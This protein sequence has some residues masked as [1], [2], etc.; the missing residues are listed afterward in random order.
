M[1][2]GRG[3]FRPAGARHWRNI[4]EC[5]ERPG[6]EGLFRPI[7]TG[8]DLGHQNPTRRIDTVLEDQKWRAAIAPQNMDRGAVEIGIEQRIHNRGNVRP[9]RLRRS[10]L[11]VR[12]RR[13]KSRRHQSQYKFLC[14][15]ASSMAHDTNN[16]SGLAS[17]SGRPSVAILL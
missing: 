4:G 5:D 2:D 13:E 7:E 11:G 17:S 15:A 6:Q 8:A 3:V 1:R 10:G 16:N 12:G 9:L 14:H